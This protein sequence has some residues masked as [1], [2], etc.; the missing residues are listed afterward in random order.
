M[1][2]VLDTLGVEMDVDLYTQTPVVSMAEMSRLG[3][4]Q[5]DRPTMPSLSGSVT[6]RGIALASWRMNLDGGA[7]QDGVRVVGSA[8]VTVTTNQISGVTSIGINVAQAARTRVVST[9]LRRY[10]AGFQRG[11]IGWLAPSLAVARTRIACAP[12]DSSAS[13]VQGRKA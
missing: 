2:T 5:G 8:D 4:Y 13:R 3:L 11:S 1:A 10:P 9:T 12:C 7:L 6:R